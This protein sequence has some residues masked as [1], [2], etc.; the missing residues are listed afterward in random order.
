LVPRII[1]STARQLSRSGEAKHFRALWESTNRTDTMRVS[2]CMSPSSRRKHHPT[3][4]PRVST[5]PHRA[6][7]RPVPIAGGSPTNLI[8]PFPT[9]AALPW[10]AETSTA[11]SRT[12]VLRPRP[13]RALA[14]CPTR[15]P[16]PAPTTPRRMGAAARPPSSPAT[17]S[18]ASWAAAAWASFTRPAR[19]GSTAPAP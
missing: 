3:R 6:L 7:P 12:S 15:T 9:R 16:P 13:R 11:R 17:R 14:R 1:P 2:V 5:I 4:T 19:P 10:P 8:Q 18:R